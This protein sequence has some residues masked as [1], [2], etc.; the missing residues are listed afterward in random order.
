MFVKRI[1]K[2]GKGGRPTQKSTRSLLWDRMPG[3]HLFYIN[4]VR[5]GRRATGF[6]RRYTGG[7]R[8]RERKRE[9]KSALRPVKNERWTAKFVV[10]FVRFSSGAHTRKES[11]CMSLAV[12]R[13]LDSRRKP[14]SWKT[15]MWIDRFLYAIVAIVMPVALY[16]SLLYRLLPFVDQ[17]LS[18][19]IIILS[20]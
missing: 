11:W 5:A 2:R 4:H 9:R 3:N 19:R 8:R 20:F 18:L 10:V 17:R 6:Y 1:K 16:K 12:M 14:P 15:C 13:C 7:E